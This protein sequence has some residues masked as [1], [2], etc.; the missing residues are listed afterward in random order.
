M[1]SRTFRIPDFKFLSQ[2]TYLPQ[3]WISYRIEVDSAFVGQ[4]IEHIEG[5]DG[6]RALLLVAKNEINPLVKLAGNKFTLQSLKEGVNHITVLS[7]IL[8]TEL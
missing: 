5:S 6:L 7:S 8:K 2:L 4:V 1:L 3:H